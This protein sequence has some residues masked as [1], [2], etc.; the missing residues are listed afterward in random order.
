MTQTIKFSK[1]FNIDPTNARRAHN[2][3]SRKGSG[4]MRRTK[5]SIFLQI[6]LRQKLLTT[7]QALVRLLKK[8][9]PGLR[10]RAKIFGFPDR[11]PTRDKIFVCFPTEFR[12]DRKLPE[13]PKV[14]RK[15]ESG[16]VPSHFSGPKT[17][18]YRE[19]PSLEKIIYLFIKRISAVNVN[20]QHSLSLFNKIE[21]I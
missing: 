17:R 15:P 8:F 16:R 4:E 21:C 20:I 19:F 18:V 14:A 7:R 2:L 9:K 12:P 1:N 5:K 3:A 13:N 6:D 10:I 11:R